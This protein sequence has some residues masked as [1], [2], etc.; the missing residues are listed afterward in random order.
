MAHPTPLHDQRDQAVHTKQQVT[1]SELWIYPIKSCRGSRV[2]QWSF[3]PQGPDWDRR[4]VV[5]AAANGLFLTQRQCP[6]LA[7][8]VPTVAPDGLSMSVAIPDMCQA[9]EVVIP[10]TVANAAIKLNIKVWGDDCQAW[11]CG[12]QIALRLSR[13]LNKDVRLAMLDSQNPRLPHQEHTFP[14]GFADSSHL[15]VTSTSSLTHLNNQMATPIPMTR[16]RP[17][18]VITGTTAYA[19]DHWQELV[20]PTQ[21]GGDLRITALAPCDRCIITTLDQTT[22]QRQGREPLRTLQTYRQRASKVYF[23]VRGII[24]G[25]GQLAEGDSLMWL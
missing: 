1:V 16:F 15:L 3:G 6:K 24:Q 18:L 9:Q 14:M 21:S 22:G 7:A 13:Y 12:D 19:E 25:K 17:N 20:P 10:A 8:I 2:T 5:V 23:G 4:F 11:D